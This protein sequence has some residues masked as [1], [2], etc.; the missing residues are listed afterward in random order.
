MINDDA[1]N[2]EF[3]PLHIPSAYHVNDSWKDKVV[4]ALAEIGAGTADDVA[5]RLATLDAGIDLA[6]AK[7]E[8]KIILTALFN[9]GLIKGTQL[10]HGMI[11]NLSKILIPNSGSTRPPHGDR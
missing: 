3:K 11:Y 2:E 6:G 9:K 5:E 8:A 4:F 10:H 7:N 1:F